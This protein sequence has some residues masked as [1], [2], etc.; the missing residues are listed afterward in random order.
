MEKRGSPGNRA[1]SVSAVP[2]W[3]DENQKKH[4][5]KAIDPLNSLENL[6]HSADKKR[7]VSRRYAA[8]VCFAYGKSA[9][10]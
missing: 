4:A 5:N 2:P 8:S 1:K 3:A 6:G 7:R 9:P 10:E